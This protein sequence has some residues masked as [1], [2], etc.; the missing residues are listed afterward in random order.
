MERMRYEG[1]TLKGQRKFAAAKAR[2]LP[3]RKDKG[4]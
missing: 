2:S 1:L 3:C 4:G